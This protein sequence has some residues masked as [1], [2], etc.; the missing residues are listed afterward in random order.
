[1]YT[2]RKVHMIRQSKI[3][4]PEPAKTVQT[5]DLKY[6]NVSEVVPEV[7]YE[8]KKEKEPDI[9]VKKDSKKISQKPFVNQNKDKYKKTVKDLDSDGF[10][11]G[12]DTIK[13]RN[14]KN[15]KPAPP[16]KV[17]PKIQ[18]VPL[19]N[20][21]LPEVMTVKDFAEAIKKTSAEVIKKLMI[22]GV[23][24]NLNQEI[25]FDTAAII[26]GEFGITAIKEVSVSEEDILFE[27]D[28]EESDAEAEPRPPDCSSNGS[29]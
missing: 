15:K 9:F 7:K 13:V 29:R 22:V 21:K 26:A 1:M 25:D 4:K 17:A 28:T 11:D 14:K 12:S 18:H 27:E 16:I 19:S 6:T 2:H 24:V 8:P 5:P 20:V 3:A 23:M 10:I